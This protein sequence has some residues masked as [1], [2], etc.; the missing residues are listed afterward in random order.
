M[1]WT[2]LVAVPAVVAVHMALSPQKKAEAILILSAGAAGFFIDTALVLTGIFTPVHYLLPPP[3][4]PPWMV[5][6][7][8]NFATAIN[9]SLNKLHGRYALSAVLGSVG[10]PSAY[11]GGAKFGATASIPDTA[12]LLVL[13]AVWAAAVP[14]LFWLSARISEKCDEKPVTT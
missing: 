12:D 10:G 6:L 8:M 11:Y 9:V 2:G 13:S 5:L 7:W 1:P 14:A 4:S 3:L